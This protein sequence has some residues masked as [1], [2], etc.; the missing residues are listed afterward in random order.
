MFLTTVIECIVLLIKMCSFDYVRIGIKQG[1]EHNVPS[2]V[3]TLS[4]IS[5]GASVMSNRASPLLPFNV[6][7]QLIAVH[8]M[9]SNNATK[10]KTNTSTGTFESCQS[11]RH[12]GIFCSEKQRANWE[13]Q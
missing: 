8:S 13:F 2:E 9:S 1:N 7:E 12:M 10:Y 6:A 4:P 3:P 11:P 5:T